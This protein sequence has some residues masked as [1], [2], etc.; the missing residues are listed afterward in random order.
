[1]PAL[2]VL[3]SVNLKTLSKEE[4]VDALLRIAECYQRTHNYEAAHSVFLRIISDHPEIVAAE[5]M[6]KLN[7]EKYLRAVSGGE[8]TLEKF[9]SL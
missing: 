4:Q 8:P 2:I 6:A 3:K 1:L 5:K 7:Y 9:T